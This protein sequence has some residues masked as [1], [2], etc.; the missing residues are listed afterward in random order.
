M[1]MVLS[2]MLMLS[3]QPQNWVR[4]LVWQGI[5]LLIYF[6]YGMH[7]SVLAKTSSPAEPVAVKTPAGKL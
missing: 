1:G 6:V 3:L 7:H 2:L 4:L 5:G